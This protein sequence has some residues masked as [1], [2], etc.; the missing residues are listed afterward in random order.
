[1]V[2]EM[3]YKTQL[4]PAADLEASSDCREASVLVHDS[5]DSTSSNNESCKVSVTKVESDSVSGTVDT[6]TATAT[7]KSDL[8]GLTIN[9]KPTSLNSSSSSSSRS[10]SALLSQE[11]ADYNSRE[12]SPQLELSLFTPS[13]SFV[14][15]FQTLT[16]SIQQ[17]HYNHPHFHHSSLQPF[18]SHSPVFPAISSASVSSTIGMMEGDPLNRPIIQGS[19]NEFCCDWSTTYSSPMREMEGAI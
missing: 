8:A 2:N 19:G 5:K 18:Y 4:S 17:H 6:T 11:E 12:G 13:A 10:S 7:E 15:P 9:S 3:S 14:T 1:M 16:P